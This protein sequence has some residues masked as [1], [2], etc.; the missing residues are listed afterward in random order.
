MKEIQPS[1][2]S[3]EDVKKYSQD[4]L[5]IKAQKNIVGAVYE[6]SMKGY[7]KEKIKEKVANYT[8]LIYKQHYTY[9]EPTNRQEVI[10]RLRYQVDPKV[11]QGRKDII[12][13][14]D[15]HSFEG[16]TMTR[17]EIWSIALESFETRIKKEPVVLSEARINLGK[18]EEQIDLDKL[19][20]GD[21]Y[22]IVD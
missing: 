22:G 1:V 4:S 2:A 13:F 6:F 3:V 17:Q 16:E 19:E 20:L 21:L 5:G 12:E 15:R 11:G 7:S 9:D 8:G 18:T 10:Q 14:V